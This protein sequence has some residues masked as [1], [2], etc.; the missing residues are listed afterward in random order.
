MDNNIDQAKYASVPTIGNDII[1]VSPDLQAKFDE[2]K[3]GKSL[4]SRITN[5]IKY[6]KENNL[7]KRQDENLKAY[8]GARL[9][10]DFTD[11]KDY[12]VK[13]ADNAI[14]EAEATIKPILLSRMPELTVKPGNDTPQAKEVAEGV[15]DILNADIKKRENR[16][17]L[18][19]TLKQHPIFLLGAIKAIW[20]DELDDYRFVNVHPKNIVVSHKA[21]S[22]DIEQVDMIAE[23]TEKTAKKLFALYPKS[24]DKLLTRLGWTEDDEDFDKKIDTP[25]YCWET[26][27]HNNTNGKRNVQVAYMYEDLVLEKTDH[28]YFDYEGND[29]YDDD[30]MEMQQQLIQAM[31][32]GGAIDDSM[33]AQKVFKN[34][35]SEPRL[36]YILIGYEQLG[37]SAYDV[38]S[39]IEQVKYQ[40]KALNEEGGRIY[41]MLKKIRGTDIVSTDSGIGKEDIENI[42]FENPDT[43]VAVKGK[44]NEVFG[45][46]E[47]QQPSVQLFQDKS[48]TKEAIFTKMGVNSTTRGVVETDTATTAQIARESDF[49]RL[50]DYAE[51]TINYATEQMAMWA[52]QFIKMFYTKEKMRR[53]LGRTGDV[54]FRSISGDMIEDGMEVIVSSSATDKLRRIN[55]A[56]EE[57]TLKLI[58]PLTYFEDTGKPNPKE[59]AERLL[60]FISNP[61][62]YLE[63]VVRGKSIED[64]TQQLNAEVPQPGMEQ[65]SAGGSPD[66]SAITSLI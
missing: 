18:G 25:L 57:A 46:F 43:V 35:F 38:T 13:W 15:S 12:Q 36:P 7:Y 3:L 16:R 11:L 53:V 21:V 20:D 54:V 47:G 32:S 31:L 37:S 49:G 61:E 34:Y 2:E 56:K 45:R 5:A 60:M 63:T 51:D 50:D 9:D 29:V 8:L 42:D 23:K 48:S 65:L 62:M 10:E 44:V 33:E 40:Q 27:F 28:P 59:R 24:K 19:L 22:S 4:Y 6:Y 26:W 52:M 41:D 30:P 17:V 66:P 39:R 58:D 14:F 64:M 1:E 55:E